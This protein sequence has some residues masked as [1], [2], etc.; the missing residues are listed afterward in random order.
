VAPPSTNFQNPCLKNIMRIEFP[1]VKVAIIKLLH[2]FQG[3]HLKR[4]HFEHKSYNKHSFKRLKA[5]EE[6]FLT[7]LKL[8]VFNNLKTSFP[9]T[10][11]FQ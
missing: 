2:D 5:L 6:F 10:S 3:L 9:H 7:P 8:D 4:R 1:K 11:N